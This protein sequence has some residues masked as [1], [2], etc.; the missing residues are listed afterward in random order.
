MR[1]FGVDVGGHDIGLHLVALDPGSRAGVVDRVQDREEVARRVAVTQRRER[2][3]RPDGGVGVLAAVLADARQI[4]LDVARIDLG[5]VEGRREQQDEAVAP[6]DEEL[7]HRGHGPTGVVGIG[8]PG[9]HA[10]RLGD[11]IDPALRVLGGAE[12]GAII[13]E[14][15]AVPVA[16]PAVALER[17][18]ERLQVGPPARR[19]GQLAAGLRDRCERGQDGMQEPAQ[20]HALAP[21]L[22]AHPVH[23][24]VPVARPD[25]RQPVGADFEA[26]VERRRTVVEQ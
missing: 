7:L 4:P 13:E 1:R 19:P 6:P 18:P 25:Q 22:I 24:V 5:M 3:D 21:A 9:E 14:G 8:G 23:A 11:R 26:P 10:P 15:P 17:P 16:V 12:R 20:P 2:D